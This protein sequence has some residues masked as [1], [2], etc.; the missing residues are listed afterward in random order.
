MST[1]LLKYT[2]I[3]YLIRLLSILFAVSLASS[4][5]A[6]CTFNGVNFKIAGGAGTKVIRAAFI[7]LIGAVVA[8]TNVSPALAFSTA[9]NIDI[10]LPLGTCGVD[11]HVS[12]GGINSLGPFGPAA[13]VLLQ[14]P[15]GNQPAG[16]SQYSNGAVIYGGQ[17]GDKISETALAACLNTNLEN[18]SRLSQ[19]GADNFN[20]WATQAYMGFTF[21]LGETAG[22]LSVGKHEYFVAADNPVHY[23]YTP[24]PWAPTNL[25]ATAGAGQVS[26]AF[27]APSDNGGSAI[28]DYEFADFAFTI[29]GHPS[30][31]PFRRPS[32]ATWTSAGT[33]TT[34]VVINGLTNDIAYL[35]KLRA[36]NS[37]GIGIESAAVSSTPSIPPIT[38]PNAPKNLVATVSDGQVSIAF[39]TPSYD[40]GAAI[41]DYEYELDS[42]GTWTSAGTTT[43]PVVITGL[44]NDVTYSI[45]LRAVNSA[46]NGAESAAVNVPLG[47]PA[48]AFAKHE[49]TIKNVIRGETNRSLRSRLSSDQR[50]MRN[51]KTRFIADQSGPYANQDVAF[52]VD[53]AAEL[54]A[55]E[56]DTEAKAKG[57][58]FSLQATGDGTW[59]KL[60]FGDFDIQTDDAKNVSGFLKGRMAFETKVNSTTIL[61]YF[62]G[63]QVG[64]ST[65]KG[66]FEGSQNSFGASVGGYLVQTLA[67][68]VYADMFTSLGTNRNSLKLSNGTLDLDSSYSTI[69]SSIGG[70]VTG[71]Y[72]ME[73][74]EVWPTLAFT[75][76]VTNVGDVG[77]TS[78]AY[79]LTDTTLRLDAGKVSLTSLSFTPELRMPFELQ[80]GSNNSSIVTFA[81]RYTCEQTGNSTSRECGSGAAIGLTTASEDGL[82]NLNAQFQYDKVGVAARQAVQL[83]FERKF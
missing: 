77:F 48:S 54:K 67:K 68:D 36:V 62:V 75:H 22:G 65:L 27:T 30:F 33:T 42:N 7:T 79:G 58:F 74:F 32:D 82:T 34:P 40:G 83:G 19:L 72:A 31:N 50:M 4:A 81:P 8:L 56:L 64:R 43:T 14:T 13:R 23:I 5:W 15:G 63:G 57:N 9:D 44:T 12:T 69:T 45:K 35:I 55:T 66:T 80:E 26:V 61:G 59:R 51:S 37:A 25:V 10:L 18:V 41:S 71:V 73:R 53:G 78:I 28:T 6:A 52:R 47:S 39:T 20:L 70:S 60:T 1:V 24:L 29:P 3:K 16:Y 11:I 76:G 49:A 2:T 21:T 46:G 17:A 38:P